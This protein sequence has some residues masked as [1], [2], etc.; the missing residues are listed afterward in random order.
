M[1]EL[2]LIL[3]GIILTSSF[4]FGMLIL[5]R[6]DIFGDTWK[7]ATKHALI[8]VVLLHMFFLIHATITA[9]IKALFT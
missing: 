4:T 3:I 1:N 8:I 5:I 6:H 7:E 9:G 2:F